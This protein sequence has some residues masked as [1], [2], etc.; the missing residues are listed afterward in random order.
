MDGEKHFRAGSVT[1]NALAY[2]RAVPLSQNKIQNI[3]LAQHVGLAV[4]KIW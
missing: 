4:I 2:D 1:D 3:F